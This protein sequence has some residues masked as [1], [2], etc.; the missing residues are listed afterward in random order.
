MS[1]Q[2]DQI[3]G[4][5]LD[6]P[7]RVPP[8]ATEVEEAILGAILIDEAAFTSIM[9]F[10]DESCF[11]KESHRIIYGVMKTL[12]LRSEPIDALT[13]TEEL[14]RSNQLERIGGA[15]FITGLTNKVPSA[16]N[17][18]T[19][20]KIV[21][22]KS[23]LR[24]LITVGGQIVNM[25]FQETEDVD[26][27]IDTVEKQIF[28]I[29]QDKASQ[30]FR[31]LNAIL[32]DA[33]EQ[34]D[35]YYNRPGGLTGVPSGFQS[36]DHITN[37]FQ[38]SNLI[39]V[40]ARPGMGKTAL[41]LNV[42]RHAAVLHQKAVGI[43]SLEMSSTDLVTRL[44]CAEAEVDAQRLRSG[45]LPDKDYRKLHTSVNNLHKANIFID[46][47][48]G[49][50]IL[51]LRARARRLKA[52]HN[53]ELLI[54]DYLQLINASVRSG[55][56]RQ[57][58]VALISRSLKALAKELSIPVIALSQLSRAVEQSPDGIV[59]TDLGGTIEYVND[60]FVNISGFSHEECLGRNPSFLQ[61][62]KTPRETYTAMW[63]ALGR[64]QSWKGEFHNRHKDG[65]EYIEFAVVA[66]IRESGGQVTHY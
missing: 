33:F 49:L 9:D 34:M 25:A 13:V 50:N 59:I 62:G 64:G 36:I 2:E 37:G 17:I 63:Q 26:T 39:I 19:Y 40:A 46:E 38:A 43:F 16:S 18:A 5:I 52:E 1:V 55:A 21:L 14:R 12:Y 15:Y 57:E 65:S 23:R 53:V 11:Y 10:L 44:L 51:D 32:H 42:A 3:N 45:N 61:S 20:T 60:A 48:A 31:P 28:D 7:G 4:K 27:L 41:V 54:I 24:K 66:P 8:Q 58:E 56:N 30:Q 35:N 29:A 47:T 6:Y 22:D